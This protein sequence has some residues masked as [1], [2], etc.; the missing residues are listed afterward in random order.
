MEKNRSQLT[1][2]MSCLHDQPLKAIAD[3]TKAIGTGRFF[4]CMHAA[5]AAIVDL[6]V[7]EFCLADRH[8]VSWIQVCGTLRHG[9]PATRLT[10]YE[11]QRLLRGSGGADHVFSVSGEDAAQGKDPERHQRILLCMRD[12]GQIVCLRILRGPGHAPLSAEALGVLD[13]FSRLLMS[14]TL[15]HLDLVMRRKNAVEPLESLSEIEACVLGASDMSRREGQV[16]ARVLYGL[17]SCGIALDLEIGRESVITYRK[18][19]YRRL[20]ISTHREL[21]MWY[22]DAWERNVLTINA[23]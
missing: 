2:S 14:I 4:Q 9:V 6:D 8:D 12:Q 3:A 17:T 1:Q 11:L 21:M 20:G 23:A 15:R 22:L 10:G 18:R 7:T 13:R 19:A 5:L 16:C